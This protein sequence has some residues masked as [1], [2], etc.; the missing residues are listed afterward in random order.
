MP[1]KTPYLDTFHAVAKTPKMSQ[2]TIARIVRR[3]EVKLIEWVM[4]I[5]GFGFK[6]QKA[7]NYKVLLETPR[8]VAWR[9]EYI[10]Q[11]EKHLPEGFL[12]VYLNEI[13]FDSHDTARMV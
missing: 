12:I 5:K 6:Y 10:R 4:F 11:I 3:R 8:I 13:W 1:E 9:W 2:S 7:D